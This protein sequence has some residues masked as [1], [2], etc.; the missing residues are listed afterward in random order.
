[1]KEQT[2]LFNLLREK[3]L[4]SS[5]LAQ[6]ISETLGVSLATA[7]KKM[8]GHVRLTWEE[9]KKLE[10]SGDDVFG[11]SFGNQSFKD[12]FHA[13]YS[14]MQMVE[15]WADTISNILKAGQDVIIS[16][17][18]LPLVYL[19]DDPLAAAYCLFQQYKLE[20]PT[21]P[22]SF[23]NF[24]ETLPEKFRFTSAQLKENFLKIKRTEIIDPFGF[25][26]FPRGLAQ[27]KNQLYIDRSIQEKLISTFSERVR[28]W[29]M[30]TDTNR[31]ICT[32]KLS[33]IPLLYNFLV[34]RESGKVIWEPFGK[35]GL[36][37][38][39]GNALKPLQSVIEEIAA[40]SS[41]IRSCSLSRAYVDKKGEEYQ[42]MMLN[43][44]Y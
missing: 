8:N 12:A 26:T 25:R 17:H 3:S 28:N 30:E 9:Y 16:C 44:D 29:C 4:S 43:E 6:W 1:M 14:P 31:K 36:K 42:R 10:R 18:E 11:D 24:Y 37:I 40:S 21:N 2:E 23:Q 5:V 38:N 33:P 13:N 27:M 20:E 35:Q 32:R 39:P 15:F 19:F 22:Q 34:I 41:E 7:Y